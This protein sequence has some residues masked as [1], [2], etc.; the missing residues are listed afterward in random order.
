MA[1]AGPF[2]VVGA[3]CWGPMGVRARPKHQRV[4][5]CLSHGSHLESSNPQNPRPALMPVPAHRTL[6]PPPPPPQQYLVEAISTLALSV[7]DPARTAQLSARLAALPIPARL[8]QLVTP[9][10]SDGGAAVGGGDSELSASDGAS[11]VKGTGQ[12]D[13]LE[14]LLAGIEGFFGYAFLIVVAV[15]LSRAGNAILLLLCSRG[16]VCLPVIPERSALLARVD[17][18]VCGRVGA[19][20][21]AVEA[22]QKIPLHAFPFCAAGIGSSASTQAHQPTATATTSTREGDARKEAFVAAL[23]AVDGLTALFKFCCDLPTLR[24]AASA[25]KGCVLCGGCPLC[26]AVIGFWRWLWSMELLSRT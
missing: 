26:A 8:Q 25:D 23:A 16:A 10:S 7:S 12:T 1:R 18:W 13:P 3:G 20:T 9:L 4:C 6:T 14:F 19:L 24:A 17:A 5:C 2:M 11:G 15:F 22:R 21:A